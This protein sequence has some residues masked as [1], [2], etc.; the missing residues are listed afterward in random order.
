MLAR[1]LGVIPGGTQTF[2]K[3]YIQFPQGFSPFFLE[4]GRGAR[5][6]DVDGNEYVDLVCGL[7]PISLGYRDPDVDAAIAAQL[8]RGIT[9]SMATELEIAVAEQLIDLIPCAEMVRFG[10]N[11]TDATSAAIRLARAHTGRDKIVAIGY[12]GWRDWYVG[13][14]SRHLGVPKAVAEL[15]VKIPYNDGQAVSDAIS[16]GD[17]AA[18]ILEPVSLEEPQPGYL[19]HLRRETEHHGTVLIFDEII[20]GFRVALDGAQGYY[21]VTPD[22]ATFGKGIANGMPLSAVVGSRE[23]MALFEDIF[24][25][26]TFG[27][28]AL[29]L[30]AAKATI[31]KMRTG[32]P[33]AAIWAQGR[34]IINGIGA[35]VE[36]TGLNQV[37]QQSGLP[38]WSAIAF[39]NHPRATGFE[40]KTLF[41]REM[42]AGGVLVNGTNNICAA[43]SDTDVDHVL[44]TYRHAF[45]VIADELQRPG[46]GD[47]LGCPPVQPVFRVR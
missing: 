45:S 36:A 5:V 44:S 23:L 31:G 24:F 10:K 22:L 20:S 35:A 30:A 42:L 1:A 40:I 41:L 46:L 11:G 4:S 32:Q 7:L 26:S 13:A 14:T 21:G 28:E 33:I 43:L 3:S 2:S 38:S 25:S 15:T 8:E 18:V 6:R 27:G 29:S 16:G 37:A 9:F 17:I 47:R 19:E 39:T 34:R 12:H